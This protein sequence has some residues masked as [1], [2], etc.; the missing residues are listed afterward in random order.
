MPNKIRRQLDIE[1]TEEELEV[2]EK[3]KTLCSKCAEDKE[4][5]DWAQENC[6]ESFFDVAL[7]L[8]TFI[9]S[10]I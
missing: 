10:S 9:D 3:A 4:L 2:L 1:W 8:K 7:A 6:R 5:E